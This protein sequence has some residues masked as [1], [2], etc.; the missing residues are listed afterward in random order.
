MATDHILYLSS[1]GNLDIFPDNSPANFINRLSTPIVLE[2][3]TEYEVGLVSI[4]YPDQYYGILNNNDYYDITV[5]TYQGS[6]SISSLP[7]SL[8]QNVLAGN[9]EKMVKIVNNNLISYLKPYY[10]D[11]FKHLFSRIKF[12]HW[13]G[14]ESKTEITCVNRDHSKDIVKDIEKITIKINRGLAQILG[15]KSN[16]EYTIFSNNKK[17]GNTRHKSSINPSSRCGVD[18]IYLYTDIIQPCNFGG[19]LVNILDCFSLQNGGNRGIH[20]SIYKP[21]NTHFL[22]QISIKVRDQ[23]ARPIYFVEESTLTCVIHIRPKY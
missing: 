20:N 6:T 8:H 22:D 3:N 19:Q 5:Y 21:L 1:T 2:N 18:Y 11:K 9:L 16:V 13:N 23:N 12:L 10:G 14:D 15:F 4:L 7:I 17:G